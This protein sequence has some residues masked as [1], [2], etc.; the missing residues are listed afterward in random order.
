[1]LILFFLSLGLIFSISYALNFACVDTNRILQ[2]SKLVAK[3]QGE[4]RDKLI[5]FQ[6]QLTTKERKL[7]E[8]K[9]QIES[10]VIS[11]QA[12]EEKMKEYERIRSE[13]QQ[14]Q[15]KAQRELEEMKQRLE[16]MVYNRVKEAAQK[17]AQKKG[18]NGILDC[19]VFIYK[20]PEIDVTTEVIKAVD[21]HLD[22][23]K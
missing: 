23:Q 3:A 22:K 14:L 7:E 5:E 13:A 2:E 11:K 6:T 9:K 19:A 4:L 21:A 18:F 12:K 8:L 17:L 16:N 1:M 15:E 20:N 10:K